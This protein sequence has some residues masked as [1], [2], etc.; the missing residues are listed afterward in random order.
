MSDTHEE[1]GPHILPVSAYLKVF[2][3]LMALTLLTY[4]VAT[5]NLGALNN[6]VMLGIA[7][8]KALLVVMIFMHLRWSPK[9][10]W[11]VAGGSFIWLLILLS[12][13]LSDLLTRGWFTAYP[14]TWL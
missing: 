4:Y 13:T 10:L 6:I 2:G 11:I 9:I 7:I 14:E 8:F 12:L 5:I 1:S 3:A